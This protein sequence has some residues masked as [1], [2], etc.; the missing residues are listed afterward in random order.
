M[1]EEN[2]LENEGA[3]SEQR[4]FFICRSCGAENGFKSKFCSTCGKPL[5]E[6]Y[7]YNPNRNDGKIQQIILFFVVLVLLLGLYG[8]TEI[9]DPTFEMSLLADGILASVI[10][11]FALFNVKETFSLYSLKNVKITKILILTALM[12]GLACAVHFV[13][14]YINTELLGNYE[15]D[16]LW[17]YRETGYPLLMGILLIG[18]YPAIFEEIAFRG[19]LFNNMLQ[20]SKSKTVIITT[21]ILF[22]FIHF[23]FLSLLWLLPIGLFFGYLRFR[24]RN[25]W[26]SSVC[27]LVYNSTLVVI[28]YYQLF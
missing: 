18:F 3:K 13:A 2:H 20:F 19:F 28:A 6:K 12:V 14:G 9:F 25:L 11:L 4:N 23:S 16:M 17:I 10:I 7:A 27:H 8:Y 21:G 24:Y 5:K 26:Y 1:I 15:D 22:A